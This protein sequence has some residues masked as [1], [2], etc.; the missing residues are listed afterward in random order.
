[1]LHHPANQLEA[2]AETR[3]ANGLTASEQEHIIRRTQAI[4]RCCWYAETLR[5]YELLYPSVSV[6]RTVSQ[7]A[8]FQHVCTRRCSFLELQSLYV[9]KQSQNIHLCSETEC[10]VLEKHEDQY[11]CPLSGNVY[12]PDFADLSHTE[13]NEASADTNYTR[14]SSNTADK[15]DNTV[16]TTSSNNTNRSTARLLANT[17]PP[18]NKRFRRPN[19]A[20]TN[21]LRDKTI[22]AVQTQLALQP[23]TGKFKSVNDVLTVRKLDHVQDRR[24]DV[25]KL[26]ATMHTLLTA[27]LPVHI[28]QD[29]RQQVKRLIM[30]LWTVIINTPNFA[31]NCF[32][33]KFEYHVLV[34]LGELDKPRALIVDNKVIVPRIPVLEKKM[35]FIVRFQSHRP[36]VFGTYKVN[37]KTYTSCRM[38]FRNSI[39]QCIHEL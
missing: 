37:S 15:K 38:L 13:K 18:P 30:K 3:L 19:N 14:T 24:A 7:S 4:A 26:E 2:V 32:T 6:Y 39:E 29:V 17:K 16:L 25:H 27:L 9:C 31:V 23:P 8:A 28:Q 11:V 10:N 1:M 36:P 21:E 20:S 5:L 33:Y 35:D 22:R 34:V 12:K